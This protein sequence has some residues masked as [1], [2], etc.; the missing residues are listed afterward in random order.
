MSTF[1]EAQL[2]AVKER[3]IDIF[4][5]KQE[6]A[7]QNKKRPPTV[8]SLYQELQNK[9]TDLGIS[10][11]T[12]RNTLSPSAKGSVDT[13][14]VL[15]LCYLWKIDTSFVFSPC[16]NEKKRMPPLEEMISS[17]EG[18]FVALDDPAYCGEFFGYMHSQNTNHTKHVA[19]FKLDICHKDGY[20]DATLY[21]RGPS[22]G[23]RVF[24]GRPMLALRK[25]VVFIIF[26][27]EDGNFFI[28]QYNYK[29]Y[30]S[31]RLYFRRGFVLTT[32][33]T[34]GNPMV[35]GFVLFARELPKS[36]E[37]Y[38]D[39]LLPLADSEF[40]ISKSV[41][42]KLIDGDDLLSAFDK[43][44]SFLFTSD[45]DTVYQVS[46]NQI[47]ETLKK[48]SYGDVSTE[49]VTKALNL[50]KDHSIAPTRIQYG[51]RPE[52]AAFAAKYL[53]QISNCEEETV[54]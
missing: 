24:H 36:K 26:T 15:A 43:R 51:N 10:Y 25:N 32:S 6:E 20:T 45:A 27:M 42:E 1:R 8:Y 18:H 5:K 40:Y 35:E 16:T 53:Q 49:E 7:I 2:A 28:F 12:F 9:H 52:T 13:T 48:Q 3:L 54:D 4:Q 41:Y 34:T 11:S 33:S 21:Y 30:G 14:T 47:Y 39:G 31:S 46:E 44:L 50:L 29:K 22:G 23:T 38:V 17:N 19:K 37:K